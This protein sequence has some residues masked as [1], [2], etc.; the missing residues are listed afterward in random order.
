MTLFLGFAYALPARTASSLPRQIAIPYD[1]EK[2][3]TRGVME[4]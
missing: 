1:F 2:R 4:F 3:L